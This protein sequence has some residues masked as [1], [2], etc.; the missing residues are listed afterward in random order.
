MTNTTNYNLLLAEGTDLV[1]YLTQ[2]NPNFS[3]LDSVIKGVSDATVSP[4]TEVT[5]GMAHAITRSL[6]DCPVLRF[7]ATSNWTTGD[8]I[9][10]DG[11]TVT[12][13]KTDGTTLKTGDYIIGSE[14]I[15]VLQ[16]TRLTVFISREVPTTASD[17]S[18]NNSG[19]DLLATDTQDAIVEVNTKLNTPLT[20]S[21][22]VPTNCSILGGGYAKIGKHVVV[23]MRVQK[24]TGT[25]LYIDGLPS[26][27]GENKVIALAM[28]IDTAN[29]DLSGGSLLASGQI[30]L[31][32]TQNHTF[33]INAEYVCN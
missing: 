2:T 33:V 29:N 26:Y 10:V 18:F 12:A 32:T 4:A 20:S 31:N 3:T 5:V 13:L 25:A 7:T 6:P 19:T 22:L 17:I 21:G 28:D 27:T 11:N 24:T 8:T 30:R 1:N 23:N 9:T 14:V 15:A 16:S